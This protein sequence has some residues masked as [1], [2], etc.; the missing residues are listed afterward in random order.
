LLEEDANVDAIMHCKYNSFGI[1]LLERDTDLYRL[2]QA[3]TSLYRLIQTYTGL[4]SS[5]TAK[6]LLKFGG[7]A[8]QK[9]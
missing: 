9:T 2:I 6:L 8:N 5:E 1:T 3:Y 7:D 4:Y